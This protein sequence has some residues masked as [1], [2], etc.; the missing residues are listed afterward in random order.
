[1]SKTRLYTIAAALA[2]LAGLTG[3][4]SGFNANVTRFHQTL[5]PPAQGQSFT[6]MPDNPQLAGSLEFAHYAD[7]VAARLTDVGYTRAVDPGSAQLIVR[8]DYGVDRGQPRVRSSGFARPYYSPFYDPFYRPFAYRSYRGWRGGYAFGFYDPFLW[9]PGYEEVET[10]V[11]Y[12][13]QL[14]LKID[15]ADG[16][17]RLFEGTA[18]AQSLSNRLTYLVPNLVDALFQGFPGQ[19]GEDIRVTIPPEPRKKG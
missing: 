8:L 3:C 5:P 4:S 10:Y 6:V 2:A 11:V 13:S 15:K 18:R 9:G 19:N 17:T 12:Q 1:M 16:G 7:L 14:T